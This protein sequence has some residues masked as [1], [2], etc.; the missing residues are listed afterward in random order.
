MTRAVSVG[1][2]QTA[3]SFLLLTLMKLSLQN[4]CSA[5]RLELSLDSRIVL[6][7]NRCAGS[8]LC[9]GVLVVVRLDICLHSTGHLALLPMTWLLLLTVLVMWTCY[10]CCVLC[11]SEWC[12][13]LDTWLGLGWYLLESN[14][15]PPSRLNIV[16]GLVIGCCL[17]PSFLTVGCCLFPSFLTVRWRHCHS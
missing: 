4:Q 3:V 12:G 14:V 15:C 2:G 7:G 5:T 9:L 10:H 1:L 17:F 6:A 13:M 16:P 11:H 8:K